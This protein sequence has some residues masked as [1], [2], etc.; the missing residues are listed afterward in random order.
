MPGRCRRSRTLTGAGIAA[1]ATAAALVLG[2][3]SSGG[4]SKE[5][6]QPTA[7]SAS[8]ALR[9]GTAAPTAAGTTSATPT[10]GGD[11]AQGAA[12]VWL[13]TRGG[14]KVQ[15]VLGKGRAALTSTS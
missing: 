8:S 3:C 5:S 15:L 14:N 9:P 11:S 1:V 13:A 7:G 10:L 4:S 12:G 2:G 6:T